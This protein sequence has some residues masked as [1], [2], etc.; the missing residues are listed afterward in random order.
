MRRSA[1]LV[2]PALAV[3][4]L[5]AAAPWHA[6]EAQQE[7]VPKAKVQTLLQGPLAGAEGK[8]VIIKHFAFPAGYVGERHSH[9]GPVF[10]Y[11]L[12]GEL[13]VETERGL[14]RYK[15]GELYPEP[16]NRVMQ[17]K[18]VS[19][20]DELEIVVFQVGDVGKPMMIKAD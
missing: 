19:A 11:V 7:Y 16:L 5:A 6:A 3:L 8:E 4:A 13:T 20:S 10:V 12:K 17:G 18:N 2:G 14:E 15:A 1:F 9:T